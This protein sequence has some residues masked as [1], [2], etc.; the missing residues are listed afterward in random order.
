MKVTN[1]RR[2]EIE[3]ETRLKEQKAK[4]ERLAILSP[5]VFIPVVAWFLVMLLFFL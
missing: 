2:K 3:L 5:G 1:K 4:E